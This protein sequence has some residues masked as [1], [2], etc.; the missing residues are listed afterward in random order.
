MD[1][2]SN[3]E[4]DDN[5]LIELHGMGFELE[6]CY[7]ALKDSRNNL[8]DALASLLQESPLNEP[9]KTVESSAKTT[10]KRTPKT[11]SHKKGRE[12]SRTKKSTR[13]KSKSL[14]AEAEYTTELDM[15]FEQEHYERENFKVV[16]LECDL[17]SI[18]NESQVVEEIQKEINKIADICEVNFTAAG[19]LL[20][21]TR[22]DSQ[23]LLEKYFD[24]PDKFLTAV[25]VKRLGKSST[26][27]K[28][29]AGMSCLVCMSDLE[30]GKARALSCGHIFCNDCWKNYLEVQIKDGNSFNI[31]CMG[32][33]CPSL[34]DSDT[35]HLLVSSSL[36]NKYTRFLSKTLVEDNPYLKWCPS[37]R[38]KNILRSDSIH[39]K[40]VV[41]SCGF[42]FCFVCG[43]EAH[44]PAT[45]VMMKEWIKKSK[46]DS[47]TFN[48]LN[49]NTKDCPKCQSA[50][51]KN[52]GCNHMTCRNCR[53]EFC[54]LCFGP[55]GGHSACNKYNE[56]DNNTDRAALTRY[57]HY[58]SR[59]NIHEQSKKFETE[60]RT[61][62]VDAMVELRTKKI[63]EADVTFLDRATNQLIECRRT[64][65]YTYVYAFSL[66]EG[67]E[68]TLFEYL[69]GDLEETTE[70]LSGVLE[71][72]KVEDS[73]HGEYYKRKS[74]VVDISLMAGKKLQH[75]LEGVEE[76]LITSANVTDKG[77]EFRAQK[78]SKREKK[79][80]TISS[81]TGST[82]QKR[83]DINPRSKQ[84]IKRDKP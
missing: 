58:W 10:S 56:K 11:S 81:P 28:N 6:R 70:K 38:C 12:K 61:R 2:T 32:T 25:G 47:E 57:L 64:L 16:G 43:D 78:T 80:V 5:V 4:V 29:C 40:L 46:D 53:H 69:Q 31:T 39:A 36:Y 42:K 20:K 37:V 49:V 50:I 3:N 24:D 54:W 75:L 45:C 21:H 41:C 9:P 17:G 72:F 51:E 83:L 79:N 67:A 7:K 48:W 18:I 26:I 60:L 71:N 76:G 82:P 23:K 15:A 77:G 66:P 44:V 19:A 68:K 63:T 1:V 35:V 62:A 34:V 22:W 65:K 13:S 27:V 14:T 84:K 59:Y 73:N 33:Q 55:W 8:E 74:V 30:K 52:G